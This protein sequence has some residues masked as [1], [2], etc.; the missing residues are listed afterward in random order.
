MA[1]QALVDDSADITDADRAEVLPA[2]QDAVASFAERGLLEGM[3][4]AAPPQP[5][6]EER[7][8]PRFLQGPPEY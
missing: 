4:P 7:A 1:V 3:G 8:A 6:R 2:V 5:D